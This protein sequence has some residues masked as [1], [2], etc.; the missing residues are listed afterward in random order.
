VIGLSPSGPVGARV[1]VDPPPSVAPLSTLPSRSLPSPTPPSSTPP[2]STPPLSS[3][4][5]LASHFGA[6]VSRTPVGRKCRGP[7]AGSSSDGPDRSAQGMRSTPYSL[8]FG[9][10]P[11]YQRVLEGF[12]H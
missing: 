5:R 12:C 6:S 9:G 1:D 8:R 10:I 3:L 7:D 4:Q 11:V 2:S